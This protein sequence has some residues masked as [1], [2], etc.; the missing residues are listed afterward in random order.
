MRSVRALLSPAALPGIQAMCVELME[1][2]QRE[3]EGQ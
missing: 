2:D 1:K 3:V